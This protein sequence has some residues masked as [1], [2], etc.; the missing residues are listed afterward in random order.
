MTTRSAWKGKERL[1][2]IATCKQKSIPNRRETENNQLSAKATGDKSQQDSP[3]HSA[4]DKIVEM[5]G[6]KQSSHFSKQRRGSYSP[7]GSILDSS[8]GRPCVKQQR[9]PTIQKEHSYVIA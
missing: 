7:A 5:P 4:I 9:G 1:K 8:V 2:S 6:G 3:R